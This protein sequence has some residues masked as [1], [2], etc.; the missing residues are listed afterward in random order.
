MSNLDRIFMTKPL[1]VILLFCVPF[2]CQSQDVTV[3]ATVVDRETNEPLGYAS[4]GLKSVAIGTIS[5]ANGEFDFHMP[6]EYR[7]EVMVISM[8]GYK[9]FEAPVW[10]LIG[11]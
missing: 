7:N 3:S 5:N 4:V 9:N 2:L 11:Q 6:A 10:S 1:L 8:L